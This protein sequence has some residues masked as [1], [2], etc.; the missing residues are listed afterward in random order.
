ML[1]CT[2]VFGVALDYETLIV[3]P[4][5]IRNA[6]ILLNNAMAAGKGAK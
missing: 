5:D 3:L 4:I 6:T 2:L 1:N